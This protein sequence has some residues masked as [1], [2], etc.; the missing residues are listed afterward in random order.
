MNSLVE[1][2]R[3]VAAVYDGRK[4]IRLLQ[5][6]MSTSDF[7]VLFADIIHRSALAAYTEWPVSWPSVAKKI[8]VRDFRDNKLFLPLLGGDARLTSVPEGTN[9]KEA[10]L[11]EQQPIT[12]HVGKYGRKLSFTFE[13]MINDDLDVL[14][15]M[16]VRLAR[17][18]RRTEE[19][20]ITDMYAMTTGPHT[21]LYTTAARN[22]VV[23][24]NGAAT[25]NPPLSVA[26]LQDAF[27]VLGNQVDESGE[28]IMV[29]MVTL[30]VPP[31][32][33]V[34]ARN[35]LSATELR[36]D[37]VPPGSTADVNQQAITAN[38][39]RNRVQL[40]VNPYLPIVTTTAGVKHT[41]WYLFGNPTVG[42]PALLAAFLRG[43]DQPQ[44]LIKAANGQT[45]NGGLVDPMNGDFETDS[46]QYRV[47]HI[48]AAARI[49]GRGTV[50]SFGT[51]AA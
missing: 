25:N 48:M 16:P 34:T 13:A 8:L 4:H 50:A 11:T 6:A 3:L 18:A 2:T 41:A 27:T 17:A 36:I 21:S 44:I 1:A 38:W 22:I 24:G 28:P 42:R 29:E 40:Q 46:I 12:Y 33:E 45:P 49:D 5:E 39:M 19:R 43:Y 51:G 30:V 31:A 9:Y 26:G 15:D 35:I 10:A 23:T 32:L 14:K 7:P 20:E 47:R 37:S